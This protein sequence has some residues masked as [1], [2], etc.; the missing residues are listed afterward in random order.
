MRLTFFFHQ[1][2]PSFIFFKKIFLKEFLI[3]NSVSEIQD[4]GFVPN[5]NTNATISEVM[6]GVEVEQRLNLT[7]GF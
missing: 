1:Q 3:I 6:N 4:A 7:V 2:L 5:G